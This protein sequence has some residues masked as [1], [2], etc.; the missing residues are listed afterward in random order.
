MAPQ[1]T[2]FLQ[3]FK[4]NVQYTIPVWQRTYSW[5]KYTILELISDLKA[6]AEDRRGNATHFGGTII[7]HADAS[8][9]GIVE[10]YTVVDGQQ[11]LTT[12]HLL[13]ACIAEY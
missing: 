5:D 9:G 13:L 8:R 3:I 1:L 10:H 4:Q 12:I 6:I 2:D 7:L 11:R